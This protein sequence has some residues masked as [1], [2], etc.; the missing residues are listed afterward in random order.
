[1][2]LILL[3]LVMMMFVTYLSNR[4]IYSSVRKELNWALRQNAKAMYCNKDGSYELKEGFEFYDEGK[5]YVIL[6]DQGNLLEGEYPEGFPADKEVNYRTLRK[7]SVRGVPYYVLDRQEL[8]YPI[9]IRCIVEK[10]R[11]SSDYEVIVYLTWVFVLVMILLSIIL[12][13]FLE[14]HEL[15]QVTR[16]VEEVGEI[17]KEKDL[18]KRIEYDDRFLEISYLVR[19]NNRMLERLE[20]MFENQK[21]FTSDVAHELRTPVTVLMAQCDCA[22]DQ[23]QNGDEVAE[24]FEIMERQAK[25]MN[26]IV[27]GMLNLSRLEQEKTKLD[28]EWIDLGEIVAAVCDDMNARKIRQVTFITDIEP[29]F[30]VYADIGLMTM[31]VQNL[32][33]NAVKYGPKNGRVWIRAEKTEHE[34]LLHIKDEGIGISQENQEK[35]FE[36]FF[37][38]EKN[39]LIEGY[40]LGLSLV[41]KIAEKHHGKITV[42]SRLGEGSVFTLHLPRELLE[43]MAG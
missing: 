13:R 37:R 29:D 40:G 23:M 26:D 18:S 24:A 15:K 21:R 42:E 30:N 11:I 34:Y 38:V 3:S 17:G 9:A 10:S 35:I 41:K 25:K 27:I 43:A 19:A 16:V 8:R 12:W 28:L 22:K 32:V 31:L 2:I 39:G 7:V 1:M 5:I 20:E 4:L 36:R 6:D 14:R 33:D